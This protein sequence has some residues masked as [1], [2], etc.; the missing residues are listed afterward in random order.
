MEVQSPSAYKGENR[1]NACVIHRR[2]VDT[3]EAVI[4]SAPYAAPELKI[5]IK[6]PEQGRLQRLYHRQQA[7]T[8]QG[9][10][11][12]SII[13]SRQLT[14]ALETEMIISRDY[15]ITFGH[16]TYASVLQSGASSFTVMQEDTN[17][18]FDA[19]ALIEILAV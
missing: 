7:R 19:E 1:T 14:S 6:P 3:E 17:G 9:A 13:I 10:A 18:S 11:R 4:K 12:V 2:G 5:P 15:I 8:T 16:A